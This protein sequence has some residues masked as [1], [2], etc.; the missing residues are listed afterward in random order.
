MSPN[1]SG[2]CLMNW[3]RARAARQGWH[4]AAM[5]RLWTPGAGACDDGPTV[6]SHERDS[7]RQPQRPEPARRTL[8]DVADLYSRVAPAYA[9][10]GPP[11]FAHTGLRLVELAGVRA[12]DNVLDLGTGR[13]AV[14]LPAAEKVG[15]GGRVLGI[16]IA[17]GMLEYT[18]R[19]IADQNLG[20]AEVQ[21]MD[22]TRL[23]QEAACFSHV[24][25]SFSVF[26]FTELPRVLRELRR[27]LRPGGVAG[28]AFSR[29]TDPRWTWYEDMLRRVGALDDM[30]PEAGY[31]HIRAPGVLTALLRDAGFANAHEQV[32]AT[33]FWYASPEQWWA[34]LW[35]HGSRRP[36]ERMSPEVLVQVEAEALARVREMLQPQGVPEHMQLVYVLARNGAE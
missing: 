26:F 15:P 33:D 28:F 12:G 9:K 32:E 19:S 36:L 17:P 31:P 11:Y 30:P 3:F 25:S 24:L 20:N 29:G 18:K 7:D 13:G 27:V 34:S 8:Q 1:G 22:A 4:L 23:E 35:T 14:L 21:L 16:D 10:E 5:G 2:D 6:H